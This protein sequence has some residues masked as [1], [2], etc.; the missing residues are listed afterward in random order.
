[1]SKL[2]SEML[3][4]TR[5]GHVDPLIGRGLVASGAIRKIETGWIGKPRV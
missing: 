2:T 4:A 1:M 5:D 3:A